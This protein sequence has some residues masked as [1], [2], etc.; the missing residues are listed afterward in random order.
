MCKLII[1][2][3]PMFSGK[4]TE[5]QRLFSREEI[6]QRKSIC[7]KPD[8]DQRYS[9]NGEVVNHNGQKEKAINA[10]DS[11]DLLNIVEKELSLS[12]QNKS[13]KLINVFIDEVQFFDSNII[14]VIEKLRNEY[15]INVFACG[16]NQTFEG[17]PFPFKDKKEHIGT[18]MALSDKVISLDAIC[19]NC[20]KVAT[21]TY[22]LG[23]SK[24]TVVIG[25]KDSYQA[26][27][28]NCFLEKE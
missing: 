6:A 15:R 20:G 23:D 16:L 14:N 11:N 21:R 1:I 19:N 25:G 12:N 5:L 10:K 13:E 8:M 24:D 2:T 22:R 4:T 27:C 3:G 9:Q 28:N 18:L 26:R 7:F 17:K